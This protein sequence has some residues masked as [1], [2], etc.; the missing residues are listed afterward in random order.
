V[1]GLLA[2]VAVA[3]GRR[4][5]VQI[6]L[7]G[8]L[9]A[10]TLIYALVWIDGYRHSGLILLTVIAALWMAHAYEGS[11]KWMARATILVGL[12]LLYCD[13][14]ALRYWTLD[15][16]Q[17]FTGAKEMATFIKANHLDRYEI[18]A[19]RP[20]M[21]EPI[22]PYLP[23]KRFYYPGLQQDGS[24]MPWDSYYN[25]SIRM[26]Y[27]MAAAE[28]RNRFGRTWLLLVNTRMRDP[29]K[30]GFH[31]IFTNVQPPFAKMDERYWLYAP[32]DW[33]GPPLPEVR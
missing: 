23:G 33:G 14:V 17:P 31:L 16:N 18:A 12:S 8:S 28:A 3:I 26:P 15:V 9:L 19:H 7:W 4:W 21:L 22:L 6:F 32:L 2:V 13:L 27:G 24:F 1:M 11:T 20:P 5:R 29:E 10:L 30:Y 25:S